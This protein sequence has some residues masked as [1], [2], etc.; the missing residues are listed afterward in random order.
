MSLECDAAGLGRQ[1]RLAGEFEKLFQVL[2]PAF[3]SKV[4][5]AQPIPIACGGRGRARKQ[6]ADHVDAT[7]VRRCMK[8]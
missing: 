7:D 4:I 6:Q 1:N 5:G 3:A 2:V 8:R